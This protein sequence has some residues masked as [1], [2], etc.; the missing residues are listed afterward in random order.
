MSHILSDF[1]TF[2]DASPTSWH[3]VKE[4]GTRLAIRDFTPLDEE[5]KWHLEPGKRYFVERGGALCAF[6][7]PE[8]KPRRA[9]ILASHTDSPA[10][11]V[12]PLPAF[13]KENMT[14]FGV[15]VYGSPLLSSWLNR[16]LKLAGRVVITNSKN[17]PEEKLVDLDDA[18]FFIPQLAIHLD[19]DV[20]EKGL[21]LNKQD[22]LSPIIGLSIDSKGPLE[23]L[24]KLLRRH[25]TFNKLLSFELFFVPQEKSRYVGIE[26]EML[27]SYRIDNLTGVH[28]SLSA[29]AYAEKPNQEMV[30]M[31]L[32][33]DNEEVGSRSKEG[34]ASPFLTDIL[35]RIGYSL[36]MTPEETMLVKNHSL[37]VSIDMAHGLNPNYSKKYEPQHTPLLGKGIVLK[38]NAD[39]KY[40]SNALSAAVIVHAC[41]TLNLNCQSYV[42]R[43]DMSCGS[44]VGPVIAHATGINTVDIGCPQLSMHSIREVMAC[45]DYLDMVNLLTHLLQEG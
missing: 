42:C 34:A 7:L 31:S 9:L 18:L 40:A 14:Q 5:E 22:H 27:A 23:A 21:Q 38:Y 32:F 10:L 6:V 39:Q 35:Q 33:W 19:R 11:K 37:C 28:A 20:N 17:E 43:S 25:H 45:Q 26:N 1:K 8:Q 24:E 15:E 29:M 12:K 16:D 13:Q 3:A 30:Q 44:T 2:L 41:Q 36:K 4:I